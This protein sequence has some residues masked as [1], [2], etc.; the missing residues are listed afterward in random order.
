M[1]SLNHG[2]GP[3][4]RKCSVGNT[5]FELPC[6]VESPKAPEAE[7]FS[8]STVFFYFLP[9]ST[10]KGEH[11]I[12]FLSKLVYGK[13]FFFIAFIKTVILQQKLMSWL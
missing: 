7:Q 1:V 8:D 9:P 13:T 10:M 11:K 2:S 4:L 5:C 3:E 6:C 12:N